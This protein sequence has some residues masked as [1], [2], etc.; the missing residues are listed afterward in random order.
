MHQLTPE[1]VVEA[2]SSS[3]VLLQMKDAV[4]EFQLV[5]ERWRLVRWIRLLKSMPHENF[6]G[7]RGDWRRSVA[8]L[9]ERRIDAKFEGA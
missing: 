6:R 1:L 7:R 3:G 5:A 4:L 8:L 9:D 2:A